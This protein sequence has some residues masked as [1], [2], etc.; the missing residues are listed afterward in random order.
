MTQDRRS[1]TR[2]PL[3]FDVTITVSGQDITVKSW[4]LSLRGMKCASN[5][6]LKQGSP[7]KIT[8]TLSP[9]ISIKLDGK[10][11]RITHEGTAVFFSNMGEESFHHLKTLLQYNTAEPDL[12]ENELSNPSKKPL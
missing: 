11:V 4:D 8:L 2:V 3:E 6:G 7:C 1:R 9:E 12:I 5:P 10:I